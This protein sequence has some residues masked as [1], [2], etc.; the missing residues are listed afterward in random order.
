MPAQK[1]DAPDRC[2][3]L[4][5]KIMKTQTT[6]TR[7]LPA[8]VLAAVLSVCAV[9]SPRALAEDPRSCGSCQLPVGLAREQSIS[10]TVF[11]S[12][13]DRAIVIIGGKFRDSQ[14]TILAEFGR[15]TVAPQH[16]FSFALDRETLPRGESRVQISAVVTFPSM[17]DLRDARVSV[18]VI[19]NDTGKTTVFI[20]DPGL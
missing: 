15:T 8:L 11:N 13:E 9:A 14:G 19:D 4:E 1:K 20:G 6:L 10:A 5:R 7:L 16:M 3:N 2:H 18:E 17:P 12:S